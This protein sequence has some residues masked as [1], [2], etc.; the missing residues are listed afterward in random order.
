M[1]IIGSVIEKQIPLFKILLLVLIAYLIGRAPETPD[2]YNY[3]FRYINAPFLVGEGSYE[4]GYDLLQ[5][6]GHVFSLD[7]IEFRYITSFLAI[8]LVDK[9]VNK[10]SVRASYL[11]LLFY[12][13]F[14]IF[15]DTEQIRSYLAFCLVITGF[16][17]L[18]FSEIKTRKIVFV[19]FVLAASTIHVSM[20][21]YL[22]LLLI[23]FKNKRLIVKCVAVV[24]LFSCIFIF[25]FGNNLGFIK[26]LMEL[27]TENSDRLSQ[28]GASKVRFGFLYPVMAH[29]LSLS[30]VLYLNNMRKESDSI[31]FKNTV[32]LMLIVNLI[33][34][35]YFP[36]YMFNLQF[37]R[38]GRG[39]MMINFVFLSYLIVNSSLKS[40]RFY[41][42]IFGSFLIQFLLFYYTF[43]VGEHVED[44][45]VP[46]F[47]VKNI[48]DT[49]G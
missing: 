24:T 29:V 4:E 28:Y 49:Y 40:H 46:F 38:L 32:E 27:A 7:Y 41:F 19:C 47:N 1:C 48:I 20:F 34:F 35:I 26:S 44:I 18:A 13:L 11:F 17:Y 8:F 21:A 14:F 12:C 33:S 36:L 31:H 5:R 23:S 25:M 22:P 2:T 30:I 6:I 42:L 39:I 9:V 16:Y 3:Y 15:I 37:F 10:L 45:I 43:F